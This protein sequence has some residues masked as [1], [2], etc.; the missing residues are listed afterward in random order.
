MDS[1]L[2]VNGLV[3]RYPAFFLDNISFSL[4]EGCVLGF[5]GANV[6]RYEQKTLPII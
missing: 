3:K 4:P 1:I 5:I 2:E 6:P